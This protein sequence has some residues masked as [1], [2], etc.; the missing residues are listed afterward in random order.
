MRQV[1]VIASMGM[2][3]L[4]NN[5]DRMVEDHS[6]AQRIASELN[7]AGFLLP[8]DGKVDTNIIFFA[9]P[10]NSK[11]TKEELAAKLEL[12]FGVKISGGYSSGG[13]MFRLVLH[14]DID[15]EG[16]DTAIEGII[17]LCIP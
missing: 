6:R 10:E 14:M 12:N 7:L 1:G 11:L 2:H 15:E 8:R 4:K 9:L 16:V 17:S 5:V 3:A 13:R